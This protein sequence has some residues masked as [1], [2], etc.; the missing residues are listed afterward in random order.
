MLTCPLHHRVGSADQLSLISMVEAHKV[1][2]AEAVSGLFT[3]QHPS[4]AR[5]L[6]AHGVLPS[7]KHIQRLRVHP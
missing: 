2:L 5:P 3:E 6:G 1:G 4:V 7:N